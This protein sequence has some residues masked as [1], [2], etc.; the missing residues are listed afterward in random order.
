MVFGASENAKIIGK[1]QNQIYYRVDI[2]LEYLKFD[3]YDFDSIL[4]SADLGE[5]V[6]VDGAVSKC[7]P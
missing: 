4:I 1:P 3:V 6:G 2:Y 5:Q 7:I